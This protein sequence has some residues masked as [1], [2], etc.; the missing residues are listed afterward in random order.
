MCSI[1]CF[2]SS[3]SL[4][5]KSLSSSTHVIERSLLSLEL[6][7][8]TTE[9]LR[10]LQH[11][12]VVNFFDAFSHRAKLGHDDRRRRREDLE[13]LKVV[14]TRDQLRPANLDQRLFTSSYQKDATIQDLFEYVVTSKRT[15][16][17]S[18]C[19]TAL[20]LRAGNKTSSRIDILRRM[21]RAFYMS[22]SQCFN[23]GSN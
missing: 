12:D 23:I 16:M 22:C 14:S 8:V 11:D 7:Q 15:P 6:P 2:N 21:P 4:L 1:W 18:R 10:L 5:L 13:F 20:L 9:L 19:F 3:V 17:L